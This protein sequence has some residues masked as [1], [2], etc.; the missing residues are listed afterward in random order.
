MFLIGILAVASTAAFGQA[1]SKAAPAPVRDVNGVWAGPVQARLNTT[2]P[3]TAWG[4]QQFEA[5]KAL[6]GVSVSKINIVAAGVSTDPAQK[7]DPAGIPLAVDWQ[8]R[9]MQFIQA[10]TKMVQLFQY[11]RAWREIWTDGRA[12]PKGAGSDAVDAP[13]PR[14]YG[15]SIG[16]W[17]GDYTFVVNTVGMD[18]RTWLDHVGHPHSAELKVEERYTRTDH[19]TIQNVVNIDDPKTFTKPYV[20]TT[21]VFHWNPKQEF[22]EQLCIPSD[23][24]AYMDAIAG[25]AAAASKSK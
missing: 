18:D 23:A 6:G 14:Y 15:Y 1:Q 21:V 5:N 24:Q 22:E 3:M 7:C 2:P 12:L 25:P 16:H 9:G 17:D 10:P 4:E 19:D 8:L 20:A 13:D 11:Q